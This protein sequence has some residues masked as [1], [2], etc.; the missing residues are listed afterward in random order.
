MPSQ[1]PWRQLQLML[2][3]PSFLTVLSI[4]VSPS[5]TSAEGPFC[6]SPLIYHRKQHSNS[7]TCVGVKFVGRLGRTSQSPCLGGTRVIIVA[8]SHNWTTICGSPGRS[9]HSLWQLSPSHYET[10]TH[11][12][13]PLL[14][15]PPLRCGSR[16]SSQGPIIDGLPH[17][18][19]HLHYIWA[20]LI[21]TIDG[22]GRNQG[23]RSASAPPPA[24][25]TSICRNL[26]RRGLFKRLL[27]NEPSDALRSMIASCVI[28]TTDFQTSKRRIKTLLNLILD[29]LSLDYHGRADPESIQNAIVRAI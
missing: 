2:S 17:Q 27:G 1:S 9:S 24:L 25:S 15:P 22:P 13:F 28:S 20:A 21:R 6:R 7:A 10:F 18:C 14:V 5:I 12:D 19:S 8:I 26:L 3:I 29:F 4:E 16:K 11:T 23:G